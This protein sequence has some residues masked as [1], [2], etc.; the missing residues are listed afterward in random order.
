MK[1]QFH[2]FILFL[3]ATAC[4]PKGGEH[5]HA[6]DHHGPA[7]NALYDQITDIHDE[8]MPLSE[9]LYNL[10]K[11]LALQ[12]KDSSTLTPEKKQELK[13]IV[14]QLEGAEEAM[15][16]WMHEFNPPSD[17]ADQEAAQAYLED[18]M[19]KI[20]NVRTLTLETIEKA[21]ALRNQ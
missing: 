20:K 12:L 4:S 10:R 13:Q 16:T 15:A 11:A 14:H 19:S 17:T 18:E 5:D 21:K 1:I 7:D 6:A 2:F 9:E 8:V 3:I